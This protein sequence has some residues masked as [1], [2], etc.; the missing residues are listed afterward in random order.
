MPW[1]FIRLDVRHMLTADQNIYIC[2]KWQKNC[3]NLLFSTVSLLKKIL[4]LKTLD[5]SWIIV[6]KLPWT[7]T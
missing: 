5:L 2:T 3:K 1:R 4:L 6:Y 7:W